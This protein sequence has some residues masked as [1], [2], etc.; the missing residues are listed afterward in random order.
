MQVEMQERSWGLSESIKEIC[1]AILI[2]AATSACNPLR[3]PVIDTRDDGQIRGTLEISRGQYRVG[4]VVEVRFTIENI[5]NEVAVLQREDGPVQD[6]IVP[7]AG[8]ERRWT[9][10]TTQAE[11]FGYLKLEPGEESTIEWSL[12]DLETGPYGFVGMWWSSNR[13]EAV[14]VAGTAYGPFRR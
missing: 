4:E 10:E 13:R 11:A 14:V 2:I 3:G 7:I 9:T 8:V 1:I 12:S 5:S 6:I